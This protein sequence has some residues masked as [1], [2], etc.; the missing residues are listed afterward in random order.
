MHT[1]MYISPIY[2]KRKQCQLNFWSLGLHSNDDERL[3]WMYIQFLIRQHS[4]TVTVLYCS[5]SFSFFFESDGES[6]LLTFMR[7]L[8]FYLLK[9][10]LPCRIDRAKIHTWF[11]WWICCST[12]ATTH[13]HKWCKKPIN[14]SKSAFKAVYLDVAKAMRCL[15]RSQPGQWV[16]P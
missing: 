4:W 3:F 6:I 11:M 13:S 1:A 14:I 16:Q 7:Q 9:S 12:I 5:G 2:H 8:F 15:D 10:C